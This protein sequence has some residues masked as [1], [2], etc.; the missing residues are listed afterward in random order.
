MLATSSCKFRREHLFIAAAVLPT[1][2]DLEQ[3]HVPQLGRKAV[4]L[5]PCVYDRVGYHLLPDRCAHLAYSKQE[6]Y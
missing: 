6:R 2:S 5:P 3:Q 4:S 1:A